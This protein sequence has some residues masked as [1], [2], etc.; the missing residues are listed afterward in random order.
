LSRGDFDGEAMPVAESSE[1]STILVMGVGPVP[2]ENPP[3]LHAPGLR[4]WTL[5]DFLRD[6]GYEIVLAM[7]GF[8]GREDE[9]TL[10]DVDHSADLVAERLDGNI[11]R[12]GLP[13][14][15]EQAAGVLQEIHARHGP[16]CVVSTTDFMNLVAVTARLPVPLWLD[17][18]GQPMTERQLLADVYDSDEGLI[19]QWQYMVPALLA[20]DRFSVCSHRQRYMMLGELGAVGRL[21]RHTATEN[22]V[23][24][25]VPY[26]LS[27][28]E[29]EH[30]R[31]VLRGVCVRGTDF[32]VLWTGG[33]N[34]WTDVDTLFQGIE[35]AMAQHRKLV[36]VSTG[37]AIPGHDDRT[38][39]RFRQMVADSAHR[40]RY[41]F[42]GWV[43]TSDV[44]NY[45]LESNLAINIDRWTVE[46]QV[47]YRTRILDW[48]MAGLPVLTTVLGELTEEL[49][50][51][52]FVTTFRIGDPQDLGIKLAGLAADCAEAMEKTNEAQEYLR[53]RLAPA[54]VL[55]PL[56]EWVADPRPAS[57]L[58][59]PAVRPRLPV[60]SPENSLAR[61]QRAAITSDPKNRRLFARLF[62]RKD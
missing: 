43:P 37:G 5:A 53:T 44:Q 22:L 31:N 47:G 18:M 7:V 2:P 59:P 28:T 57:D 58:P 12:Y 56:A 6:L 4:L 46:G 17:Y 40:S 15:I 33:Y 23:E 8:G 16:A 54:T 25:L 48:I 24:V 41:E 36:F 35:R 26:H 3:R 27:K 50:Q 52:R 19:G 14:D 29:F 61:L 32:V 1:A 11:L 55:A 51:K 49:A 21:N 62:G 45:Y 13:Y 34:T 20:G 10:S 38:F 42:C 30:K 39:E 60:W 9:T